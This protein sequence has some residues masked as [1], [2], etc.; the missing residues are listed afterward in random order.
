MRYRV[1][2]LSFLLAADL[3]AQVGAGVG[4]PGSGNKAALS[5]AP[6]TRNSG[7]QGQ[8][9]RG[10]VG[11]GWG[12]RRWVGGGWWGGGYWGNDSAA[13]QSTPSVGEAKAPKEDKLK[14][15]IISPVYEPAKV[16]PKM[17]EIP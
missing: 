11:P 12:G 6:A 17:I 8:G 15:L 1:S 16:N 3:S 5:I 14:E 13:R 10:P 4:N 2:L 7:Q 9:Q